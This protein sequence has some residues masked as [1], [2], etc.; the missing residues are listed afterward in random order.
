MP[1]VHT[2]ESDL[3]NASLHEGYAALCHLRAE[4]LRERAD[5]LDRQAVDGPPR[6]VPQYV[7]DAL[8][9]QAR[10]TRAAVDAWETAARF[11]SDYAA[12][13]R[14]HADAASPC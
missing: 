8:Q 14:A 13:Y 11:A 6:D 12:D 2:R 10:L 3:R 9:S 5:G 7:A 4:E 1:P